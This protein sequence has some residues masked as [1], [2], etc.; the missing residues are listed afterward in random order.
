MSSNP[1]YP[2]NQCVLPAVICQSA[3]KSSSTRFTGCEDQEGRDKKETH[4]IENDKQLI[5]SSTG[6]VPV[7]NQD[8]KTTHRFPYSSIVPAI[9]A[10][11]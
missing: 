1:L 7:E 8:G 5:C 4:I 3:S 6:E 2:T 10:S 11:K 9:R